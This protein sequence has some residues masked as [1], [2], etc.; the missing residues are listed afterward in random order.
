MTDELK[1]ALKDLNEA[2]YKAQRLGSDIFVRWHDTN[3]KIS[4][5]A[6]LSDELV[7]AL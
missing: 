4:E 3:R 2:A 5:I 6:R 7:D 1:K